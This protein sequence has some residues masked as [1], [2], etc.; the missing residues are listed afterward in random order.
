MSVCVSAQSHNTLTK[1]SEIDEGGMKDI[2]EM[3]EMKEMKKLKD[4]VFIL[5]SMTHD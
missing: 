3:K 4:R 1:R 5:V 2:K